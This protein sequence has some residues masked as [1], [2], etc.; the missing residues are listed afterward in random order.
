LVEVSG[1]EKHAGKVH[2]IAYVEL[3]AQQQERSETTNG[4]KSTDQEIQRRDDRMDVPEGLVERCV[5][6]HVRHAEDFNDEKVRV[7]M[8]EFR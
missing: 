4:V 2:D 3:T 1:T 6:E 7:Q 8:G 5:P